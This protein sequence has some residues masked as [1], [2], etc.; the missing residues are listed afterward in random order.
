MLERT[1]CQVVPN[2]YGRRLDEAEIIG[3]HGAWML[4][5]LEKERIHS[6]LP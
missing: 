6:F 5:Q 3:H 1:G 4:R 2:P